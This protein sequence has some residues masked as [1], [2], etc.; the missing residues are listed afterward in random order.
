[1]KMEKRIRNSI[2]R[3]VANDVADMLLLR[4]RQNNILLRLL[5]LIFGGPDGR[6]VKK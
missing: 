3:K 6:K 2:E 1:M 5:K 4:S